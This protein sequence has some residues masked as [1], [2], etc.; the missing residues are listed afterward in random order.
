MM[1]KKELIA[2]LSADRLTPVLMVLLATS[3]PTAP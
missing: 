3:D 1:M 2:R